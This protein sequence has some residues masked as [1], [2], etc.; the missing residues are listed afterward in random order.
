MARLAKLEY[1]EEIQ[2][3]KE[4]HSQIMAEK[5]EAQY[6]KHYEFC[7]GVVFD[8]VDFVSK[9]GEYRELTNK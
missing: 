3:D 5:R 4:L 9:I 6:N 7:Q 1:A 8:I 2:R